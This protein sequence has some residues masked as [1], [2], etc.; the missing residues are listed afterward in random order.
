MKIEHGWAEFEFILHDV[1]FFSSVELQQQDGEGGWKRR[2]TPP[3]H[4]D[5]EAIA[6]WEQENN[7]RYSKNRSLTAVA[8]IPD[9][10]QEMLIGVPD[11]KGDVLPGKGYFEEIDFYLSDHTFKYTT[12]FGHVFEGTK[13]FKGKMRCV[14]RDDEDTKK[15]RLESAIPLSAMDDVE[16]WIDAGNKTFLLT[17]LVKCWNFLGPIGDSRLYV[18][19]EEINPVEVVAIHKWDDFT[20]QHQKENINVS[21]DNDSVKQISNT[22]TTKIRNF[23]KGF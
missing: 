22:I 4:F 15:V 2:D 16:R 21:D 10:S 7:L 1:K 6:K 3:D 18:D 20:D 13:Y 17:V 12:M 23:V 14:K 11:D 9:S 19:E 5:E 8:K